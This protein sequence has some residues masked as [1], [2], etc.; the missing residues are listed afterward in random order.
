MHYR[1][2]WVNNTL[3]YNPINLKSFSAGVL[4]DELYKR[5][6]PG[7]RFEV[8]EVGGFDTQHGQAKKNKTDRLVFFKNARQGYDKNKNVAFIYMYCTY[9]LGEKEGIVYIRVYAPK[10]GS[11]TSHVTARISVI[12]NDVQVKTDKAMLELRDFV[13]AH[14]DEIIGHTKQRPS[15]I[16]AISIVEHSLVSP[17]D[18]K[19]LKPNALRFQDIQKI[20]KN[21]DVVLKKKGYELDTTSDDRIGKKLHCVYFKPINANGKMNT[22]KTKPTVNIYNTMRLQLLGKMDMKSVKYICTVFVDAYKTATQGMKIPMTDLV[23][24]KIKRRE[25]AVCRKNTP[26]AARDG[27][28]PGITIP[29]VVGSKR[30]CCYKERLFPA[31]AS[32]YTQEFIRSGLPVPKMYEKYVTKN[33]EPYIKV[34]EGLS[35][36]IKQPYVKN[37][38]TIYK[39][40]KCNVKGKDEIQRVGKSILKLDMKKGTKTQLCQR[41]EH[42]LNPPRAVVAKPKVNRPKKDLWKLK[43]VRGAV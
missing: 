21:M 2:S 8:T 13:L 32:E 10:K 12:N 34:K 30:V 36:I 6:T 29:K 35:F 17:L 16:S 9:S 26:E 24:I 31:K 7:T 41:I 1:L 28:C 15:E 25:V 33:A 3:F 11:T 4:R 42:A 22:S 18:G 39:A 20:F 23:P 40:W 5:T 27:T 38:K 19:T 43:V 14:V 37:G